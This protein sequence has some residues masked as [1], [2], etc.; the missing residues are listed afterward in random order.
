M[1]FSL[2]KLLVSDLD[3]TL[4]PYGSDELSSRTV[5]ALQ[6]FSQ[7]NRMFT[8]ATG[9]SFLQSK[10]II[11]KLG[12][13]VPVIVQTGALIVEPVSGKILRTQPLNPELH[14]QLQDIA[15]QV[16]ADHLVLGE[17]GIYYPTR[18]S[19][20][21]QSW[22]LQSGERCSTASCPGETAV[23]IKHLFIGSEQQIREVVHLVERRAGVCPHLILWPPDQGTA[24]WFLEVFDPS[25]SK[26]QALA[27]LAA[28]L[29]VEMKAVIAFG[30]GYNDMDMLRQ[31]GLGIA[32]EQAPP[33]IRAA[34]GLTIPGP[35]KDGIA[36]FVADLLK[37]IA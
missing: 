8:I 6:E 21:S 28:R 14:Q 24:D 30:D 5:Q 37:R 17:D 31:A 32:M 10:P 9:R 4:V 27:W 11:D 19:L 22:L 23:V 12:L 34:A 13:E 36:E 2:F 26:G 3:G 29:G 35:E 16:S 18:S 20:Q 7:S 15:G 33:E 25:A 1:D